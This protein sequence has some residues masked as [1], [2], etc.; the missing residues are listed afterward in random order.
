MS[1]YFYASKLV[2]LVFKLNISTDISNDVWDQKFLYG[3][4]ILSVLFYKLY[5]HY[6]C[7]LYVEDT[8]KLSNMI[9]YKWILFS[10][11]I[12]L[13]HYMHGWLYA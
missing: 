3:S 1:G 6:M 9:E 12:V 10:F 11:S 2:V 13:K 8:Y 7:M 4:V 5:I